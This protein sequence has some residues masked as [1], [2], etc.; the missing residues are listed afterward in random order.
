VLQ[1]AQVKVVHLGRGACMARRTRSASALLTT[2]SSTP[3]R[4]ELSG[5]LEAGGERGT[6][7]YELSQLGCGRSTAP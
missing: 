1:S 5:K 3:P 7:A 4:I 6:E 2:S